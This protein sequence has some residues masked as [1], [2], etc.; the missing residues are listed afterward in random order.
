VDGG[1]ATLGAAPWP[2]KPYDGH[3]ACN[4]IKENT[5]ATDAA[6]RGFGQNRH[7]GHYDSEPEGNSIGNVNRGDWI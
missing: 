1:V 3:T 6:N 7:P 2:I 5:A 4:K